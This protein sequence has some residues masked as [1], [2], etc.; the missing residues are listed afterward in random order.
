VYRALLW[1]QVAFYGL[2]L[3]GYLCDRLGYRV[4][5][6][7]APYYFV[8]TN[9]AVLRGFGRFLAGRQPATWERVRRSLGVPGR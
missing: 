3:A 5:A 6:L 1:A 7:A 2:A 9:Y 4:T 8:V